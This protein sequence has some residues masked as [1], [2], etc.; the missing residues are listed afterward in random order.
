M[1]HAIILSKDR[2]AQLDLALKA[3]KSNDGGIFSTYSILYKASEDQFE[4]GYKCLK[5]NYPGLNW[6]EQED[7]YQNILE[8]V[9]ESH[10]FTTFF[11][12]DDIF[13]RPINK[14]QIHIQD[15][16]EDMD[17]L[18]CLSLRLGLNTYIQDPYI[19]SQVI[20][21]SSNFH[22]LD[23]DF[24]VWRWQDCPPYGNFGYPLSV[25]GHIFRT[26]ELK[27]IL[28]DC[29]FNNP[30]QQEI[31]MQNQADRLPPLMACFEKSVVI[32]TPLNRVQDTCLNR[33]GENFGQSAKEMND[34]FIAGQR[35]DFNSIDFSNIIG[36]HQELEIKWTTK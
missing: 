10:E 21:P 24:I 30:N 2:A 29:R 33:S 23:N 18:A 36:C 4:S 5:E 35:L 1:I 7:Y 3:L 27:Q 14:R 12:D 34:R 20:A 31:A 32:N 25:D 26:N 15:L 8:L 13:Y 9:D 11:T 28:S 22:Y 17:I 16:F 19:G 6:V